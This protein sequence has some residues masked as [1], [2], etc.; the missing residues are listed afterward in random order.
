MKE[1]QSHEARR[2]AFIR[3][4]HPDRGGDP[5][6]FIAGLR[7]L[8]AEREQG[9][10]PLPKVVVV[11]RRAWLVRQAT[12][13]MRRLRYGS[14]PSRVRLPVRACSARAGHPRELVREERSGLPGPG[15]Q[16]H[17]RPA[18]TGCGLC[19]RTRPCDCGAIGVRERHGRRL[20][21]RSCSR[22]AC[23]IRAHLAPVGPPSST[24]RH[25]TAF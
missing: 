3:D 19:A 22:D 21:C 4:H 2:R 12:V 24:F 18:A 6:A 10:R 14:R 9:S 11:R 23:F 25:A 5:G 15:R 8:D 16:P 1:N 20:P 13:L 7:T 17:H